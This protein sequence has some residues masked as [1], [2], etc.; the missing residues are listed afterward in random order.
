M[1]G[2]TVGIKKNV[3]TSGIWARPCPEEFNKGEC[4][5]CTFYQ[6]CW[7]VYELIQKVGK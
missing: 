5:Y 7:C 2:K 6:M 1:Y 3:C 4:R